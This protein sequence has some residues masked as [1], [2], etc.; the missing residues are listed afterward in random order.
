MALTADER[1]AQWRRWLGTIR[2]EVEYTLHSRRVYT[3]FWKIFEANDRI[4]GPNAFYA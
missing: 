1:L 3:E 4:G 2:G